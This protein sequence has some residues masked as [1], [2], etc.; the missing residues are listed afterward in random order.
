[1]ADADPMAAGAGL[2][3]APAA[4][5]PVILVSNEVGQGIVPANPLARRFATPPAGCTKRRR[6][7][8][9]GGVYRRW[10][11]DQPERLKVE[12]ASG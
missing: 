2:V 9:A 10:A 4:P 7:R 1:M 12:A 6:R 3:E 8:A 5:G 11:A